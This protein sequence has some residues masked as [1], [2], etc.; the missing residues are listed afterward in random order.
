[1]SFEQEKIHELEERLKNSEVERY[2]KKS[3]LHF[4]Q[5][6]SIINSFIK[7]NEQLSSIEIMLKFFR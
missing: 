6:L 4:L 1:M 2:T 3:D 7:K 5:E